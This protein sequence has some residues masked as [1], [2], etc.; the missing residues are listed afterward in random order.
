MH[1]QT[2]VSATLILNP[3]G[4]ADR[5][6]DAKILNRILQMDGEAVARELPATHQL[7]AHGWGHLVY[8]PYLVYIPEK[9][10]L[11]LL[12]NSRESPVLASNPH[13]ILLVSDDHG[14]TWD[15]R[16]VADPQGVPYP[17]EWGIGLAYLGKGK[18][19]MDAAESHG[20]RLFS[21]DYGET[22]VSAPIPK[23]SSGFPWA[24]WDSCFADTDPVTGELK[25]LLDPGYSVGMER[26][27]DKAKRIAI[28][29]VEWHWRHDPHDRGLAEGWF[30]ETAWSTWPQ[31]MQ[32]D[33][34]WTLQGE[35]DGIGW[36]GTIF[37]MPETGNAPLAIAFGAVDGCCDVFIDGRKVG[38]Q[39]Q[40]PEIMWNR[41]FHLSLKTPLSA[42]THTMVIRVEKQCGK[43]SN[44]GIYMPVWIVEDPGPAS[45]EET[46]AWLHCRALI[47]LSYDGGLTW[48]EEIEP[49]SWNGTSGVGVNE[50]ALCRAANNDL[51][52]ACRLEHPKYYDTLDNTIIDHYCGLGVSLSKDNGCTWSNINVLYEYGRM[53]P[54]LVV[55]PDGAI[56]MTYVVRLGALKE[57]HRARDEDG[58]SQWGVE[59]IVSRDHGASW[60]LAHRYVLAKWSGAA[61]AQST[62]TV[63]LPDGSLLTACGS[64]YLSRPVTAAMAPTQEVCLVHWRPASR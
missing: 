18:L 10:R 56:V 53:H 3:K 16:S 23:I 51:I 44:A 60:D 6:P 39:K 21:Q 46:D 24:H 61:Q 5:K 12:C 15:T 27:F 26:R 64:G 9:D 4:L 1:G 48:P 59:A 14:R 33:R 20:F 58:F 28:L 63:L 52:A 40:P 22:W 38:E 30:T 47:R 17:M 29:P 11:L 42:G 50:V 19:T 31:T 7:V 36:Y 55:L 2:T 37:Q 54:S 45:C 49:P 43:E 35:P 62:A 34:H 32:I 13:P 8:M 57:E 25:R 41:P